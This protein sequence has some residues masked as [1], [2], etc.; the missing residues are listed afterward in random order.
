MAQVDFASLP[1]RGIKP[2][3]SFRNHARIAFIVFVITVILGTPFV[4]IKGKIYYSAVASVEVAPKYMKNLRDEGEI[5]LDSNTQYREFLQ[6]QVSSVN[7]YDIVRDALIS[8]GDKASYW[9]SAGQTERSAVDNLRDELKVRVIPDTYLMEIELQSPNQNNLDLLVNAIANTYIQRMRQER[10]FGADERIKNLEKRDSEIYKSVQELT[11]QRTAIALQL[12]IASFTG[13]EDN[14]YDKLLANLRDTLADAKTKRFES[15]AEVKAFEMNGDTNLRTK[16]IQETVSMDPG[17]DKLKANIYKRRAELLGLLFGLQPSHP[18]YSE[19]NQELKSLDVELDTQTAKVKKEI[20]LSYLA[21][22]KAGLD[23]TIAVETALTKEVSELE[24]SGISFANSYNQA[25]NLTYKIDQQRKEL[26]AIRE[27]INT[28]E[29]EQNSFGFVRMTS[30]ALPPEKPFG[31]GKKKIFMLLLLVALGAM[32]VTPIAIDLLDRRIH[33]VND[34]E[35]IMGIRAMGWL[36][37]RTN[38]STAIFGED[39][40][41]RIAGS[42]LFEQ[43]EHGTQVFAFSSVKPGAGVSGMV[44]DLAKVLT[45]MGYPTLSIDANAFNKDARFDGAGPGLIDCLNGGI[46]YFSCISPAN[47]DLPARIGLG[48]LDNNRYLDNLGRI[49][50]VTRALAK[51][52]SFV[53][54]DLPAILISA[55]AE[56]MARNLEHLVVVVEANGVTSGELQRAKRLLEKVDPSVIGLIVN[57]IR[58][59]EGG[60]YLQSA[61]LEQVSGQNTRDYFQVSALELNLQAA[62]IQFQ[63]KHPATADQIQKIFDYFQHAP[64]VLRFKTTLVD[65]WKNNPKLA[66]RKEKTLASIND[67]RLKLHE[68]A[69]NNLQPETVKA[70]FL[71]V[72]N[73]ILKIRISS[74]RK[75]WKIFLPLAIIIIAGGY[76]LIRYPG[77]WVNFLGDAPKKT[78]TVSSSSDGGL[79]GG[80]P[81]ISGDGNTSVNN[82]APNVTTD[83]GAS[84]IG[85]SYIDPSA[86]PSKSDGVDGKGVNPYLKPPPNLNG[87]ANSSSGSR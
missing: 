22:K 77:F 53:L 32:F 57:R 14:P 12:G 43:K 83:N 30:P 39:L 8:L 72:R 13:K 35:K 11:D 9:K 40:L 73:Q 15:E 76:F 52:F 23:E 86:L 79:A 33:T 70:N 42:M 58:P 28:I 62:W 34:A 25:V 55:D 26:D 78:P 50:E 4:F 67:L 16:S 66:V 1:G 56:I 17:L 48:G 18:A 64:W 74:F 29:A 2:L 41:R 7:R 5:S 36:V 47:A 69:V 19:L 65:F 3:V 59:F 81:Q 45:A 63:M 31:P 82:I 84:P 85:F 71:R 46:D 68:V 87:G 20:A 75:H 37:E 6:N 10:V 27:R 80:N 54:V 51:N 38:E 24:K 44:L 61:M 49:G 60:G 21:R